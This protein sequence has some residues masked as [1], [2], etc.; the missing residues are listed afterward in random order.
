MA[1]KKR[2][3]KAEKQVA[4]LSQQ[5][6]EF[7]TI[8]ERKDHAISMLDRELSSKKEQISDL[9][10]QYDA[11]VR[12]THEANNRYYSLCDEV[13]KLRKMTVS[14][15]L[16]QEPGKPK[17]DVSV[18]RHLGRVEGQLK[19]LVDSFEARIM[20]AGEVVYRNT[21]GSVI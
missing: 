4:M 15:G 1:R 14:F 17:T 12:A 10:Q 13:K 18:D 7:Q 11:Q 2:L 20:T 3:T 8:I 6:A 9:R 16:E 21:N 19:A 5:V